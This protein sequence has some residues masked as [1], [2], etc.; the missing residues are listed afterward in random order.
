[1]MTS[2]LTEKLSGI[3]LITLLILLIISSCEHEKLMDSGI[4]PVQPGSTDSLAKFSWIQVNIFNQYC[5]VSGC[6]VG[7]SNQLPGSMDLREGNAYGNI[8]N[9]P[10]QEVPGLMRVKPGQP[11]SSYIVWKIE[12]RAGIVGAR[13][14]HP[15]RFPNPLSTDEIGAIKRW[16]Q[17]ATYNKVD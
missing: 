6:H 9:F 15:S 3:G 16:I 8:V 14:P 13:M 12:N 4:G 7:G 11:D 17:G 5:A 10:S 1:M 2:K